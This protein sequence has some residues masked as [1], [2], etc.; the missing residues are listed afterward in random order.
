MDRSVLSD[1]QWNKIA[2]L[3]AG[4]PGDPGRSG[5]D[6]RQ[7]VEAVLWI[8][9]TGAPWRDLPALF[10]NW[11]A[12]FADSDEGGHLFQSDR[13]HHSNLMAAGLDRGNLTALELLDDLI[14]R[15]QGPRHAQADQ[16]VTDPLDRR[17][18]RQLVSH[19]AASFA[20]RRLPTAS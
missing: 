3:L 14:Q 12:V 18:G 16:V 6:N 2:P 8:A 11:N 1:A 15:F 7:F 4:K 20:A 17:G 9:R 13:G 19:A 10:G 5:A